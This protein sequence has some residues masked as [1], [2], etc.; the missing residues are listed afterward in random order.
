[1]ISLKDL[2]FLSSLAR[3]GHFARAAEEC[4]VSQPA[5]SM[6]I[7]K[8]EERLDAAIVKRGNRFQG[9]TPEGE[10]LVR[11]ARKIMDSVKLLEEEFRS[12]GGEVTGQ[13]SLAVIPT[14]VGFAAQAIGKLRAGNPAITVRLQ[15]ASSLTIQ[16]GLEKRV[17]DAGIT[18]GEGVSP[19]M[20]RVEHLYEERYVLVA[21]QTLAPRLSGTASWAE[22]AELP[23][24]LLDPS[25]Q[26][27]RILDLVF[28]EAGLLPSVIAET[29]EFT[30]SLLMAANGVAATVIPESLLE[31][32]GDR[33]GI[34]ALPLGDPAVEKDVSLVTPHRLP[35]LSTVEALRRVL[36]LGE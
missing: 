22:A 13:L 18:Y 7:R 15:T 34:V 12:A 8:L 29:S 27:R 9:F 21:P 17:F 31:G 11:H 1:M 26:N 35:G 14:A 25:M 16:Q 3:H 28:R 4:G 6:R 2:E 20:M 19:E 24:S 5:F 32:L 36:N 30:S 23:L 33:K 10:A